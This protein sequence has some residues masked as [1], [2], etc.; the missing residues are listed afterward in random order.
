MEEAF[1]NNNTDHIYD[2]FES[3]DIGYLSIE[4]TIFFC[5]F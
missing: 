2:F 1:G 4:Y 3:T 5:I